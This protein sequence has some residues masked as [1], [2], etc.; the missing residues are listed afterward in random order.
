MREKRERAA[1]YDLLIRPFHVSKKEYFQM[2]IENLEKWSPIKGGQAIH[3]DSREFMMNRK[4]EFD[5]MASS[6][7]HHKIRTIPLNARINQVMPSDLVRP[8]PPSKE[9]TPA[10]SPEHS[11]PKKNSHSPKFSKKHKTT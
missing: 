11:S 9:P 4:E 7:H 10:G 6:I 8:V 2:V 5:L 1:I 3:F